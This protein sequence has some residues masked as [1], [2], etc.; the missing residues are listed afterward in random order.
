ML[1]TVCMESLKYFT[2]TAINEMDKLKLSEQYS[3]VTQCQVK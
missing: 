1:E 3:S 2:I